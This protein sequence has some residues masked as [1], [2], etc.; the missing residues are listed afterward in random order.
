MTLDLE[1]MRQKSK[2]AR[3]RCT[4][5]IVAEQL[6]ADDLAVVDAAMS[7]PGITGTA[8]AE[9]LRGEGHDITA[10]TVQRHR[11]GECSCGT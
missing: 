2:P 3:P 6:D 4:F 8:I 10:T 7:D 9:V 1:A 5:G 11:R